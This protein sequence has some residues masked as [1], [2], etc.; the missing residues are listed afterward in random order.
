MISIGDIERFVNNDFHNAIISCRTKD[1]KLDL[2]LSFSEDKSFTYE[3]ISCFSRDL[4]KLRKDSFELINYLLDH[5]LLNND[6]IGIDYFTYN[7]YHKDKNCFNIFTSNGKLT[8]ALSKE[9][10]IADLIPD[11]VRKLERA[12]REGILLSLEELKN[13][14][15]G[16]GYAKDKLDLSLY[17]SYTTGLTVERSNELYI[18]MAGIRRNNEHYSYIFNYSVLQY[19]KDG[20]TI[21]P[22][23]ER[24]F[25]VVLLKELLEITDSHP[26]FECVLNS[27]DNME[28][29]V[30][31]KF[32][33]EQ[34]VLDL[35]NLVSV[36]YRGKNNRERLELMKSAL[37]KLE[38][39]FE[40]IP[41][42]ESKQLSFRLD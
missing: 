18:T 35:G 22:K 37:L 10:S 25:L 26:Y 8:L 42:E 29:F 3:G 4:K 20:R 13:E 31:E 30:E 9:I 32:F 16:H 34:K 39:Y 24:E 19:E 41:K 36:Y 2:H 7:Q 38:P 40:K 12:K 5:Y 23:Y 21:I 17:H 28:D 14:R 11:F 1:D 33:C 6:V 27:I 15:M